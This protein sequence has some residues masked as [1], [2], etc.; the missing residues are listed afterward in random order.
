[1]NF[2]FIMDAAT[3]LVP[4]LVHGRKSKGT[5]LKAQQ[6]HEFHS[7]C[8]ECCGAHSRTHH[9][10]FPCCPGALAQMWASALTSTC[11]QCSFS[12]DPLCS[13]QPYWPSQGALHSIP[14]MAEQLLPDT[15]GLFPQASCPSCWNQHSWRRCFPGAS[16]TTPPCPPTCQPRLPSSSTLPLQLVQS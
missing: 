7:A 1:M 8:S 15:R 10:A 13:A 4:N 14:S 3:G 5:Y 9:S 16:L 2:Q 11:A 12:S 6:N